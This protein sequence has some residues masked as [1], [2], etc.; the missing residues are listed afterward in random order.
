MKLHRFLINQIPENLDEL[1][2]SDKEVIHQMKKV[3]RLVAGDKVILLDGKGLLLFGEVKV[4]SKDFVTI[5]KEKIEHQDVSGLKINLYSALI[6]KD[7]YEWVLQKGTEIGVTRFIPIITKRTEKINLNKERALK[8]VKEAV[9][10]SGR[11]DL[12][13]IENPKDLKDVCST[14]ETGCLVFNPTG[15]V[16]DVNHYKELDE[17]NIFIGPEGGFDESEIEM[18]KDNNMEIVS[19]GD[20]ILRAETAAIIAP[21]IFVFS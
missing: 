4:I 21:S 16:L 11:V 15:S 17:I 7:K 5:L 6:K 8:I 3:L 13:I 10:Q 18:F 14:C 1:L 19:L 20:K 2:I 12:P 9:E